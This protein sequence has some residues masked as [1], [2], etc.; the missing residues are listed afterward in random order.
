MGPSF[1]KFEHRVANNIEQD[2]IKFVSL[3]FK[4]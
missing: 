3:L 4:L 2:Y 1:G